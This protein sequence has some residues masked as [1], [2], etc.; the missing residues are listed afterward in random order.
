M[1][2]NFHKKTSFNPKH[3]LIDH[4]II[5]YKFQPKSNFSS[6]KFKIDE[7]EQKLL[8]FISDKE[9]FKIKSYF[10]QK[11]TYDFLSS[12]LK[13][14]EK[15]NLDDY[16]SEGKFEIKKIEIDKK[17]FPKSKYS[18]KSKDNIS[19][20]KKVNINNNSRKKSGKKN[21]KNIVIKADGTI[22]ISK[23]KNKI[24]DFN[25]DVNRELKQKEINK[26]FSDKT[27]LDS[28]INEMKG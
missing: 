8:N 6:C 10:D 12:K 20:K 5:D 28:I 7:S 13:A 1:E 3:L 2:P 11:G 25:L 14:M 16:C 26:F 4:N 18:T 23:M 22:E 21:S 9:K 17:V 27:L 24:D 15:M 19:S